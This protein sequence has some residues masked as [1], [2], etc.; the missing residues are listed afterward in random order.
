MKTIPHIEMIQGRRE[1]LDFGLGVQEVFTGD[2]AKIN[3]IIEKMNDLIDISNGEKEDE[4][5]EQYQCQSI[6]EGGEVKNCSC[7]KCF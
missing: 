2:Q 1:V 4:H 6:V 5:L 7:G 3:E